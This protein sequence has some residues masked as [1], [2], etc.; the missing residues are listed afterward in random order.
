MRHQHL[1]VAL[2]AGADADRGDVQLARHQRAQLGGDALEHDGEAAGGLERARVGDQ[3]LLVG[4][5]ARLHLVAAERQ[6]RLR[7]QSQVAHDRDAGL[8]D[9][10]HGLGHARTALELDGVGA[11]L[12]HQ[13][14]GVQHGLLGA[15]LVAHE[16]HVPHD[17]RAGLRARDG[18]RVVQHVVHRHR[19]R[20]VVAEH[21]RAHGVAHEQDLDAGLVGEPRGREVVRRDHRDGLALALERHHRRGR[22]LRA[23]GTRAHPRLATHAEPPFSRGE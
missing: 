18:A 6:H 17:H 22:D 13:P 14:A 9:A 3:A 23:R 16:R 12:L 2:H 7:R 8:D 19:Q 4:L 15:G 20:A 21:D 5:T 10:L 1:A 11:P